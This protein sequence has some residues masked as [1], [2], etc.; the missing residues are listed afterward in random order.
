[1]VIWKRI[2][3]TVNTLNPELLSY[4]REF[5]FPL[6]SWCQLCHCSSDSR[7]QSCILGTVLFSKSILKS[8]LSIIFWFL[9]KYSKECLNIK[10][11]QYSILFV[12]KVPQWSVCVAS[13]RRWLSSVGGASRL[14]AK[15]S[16]SRISLSHYL[17]RQ[18]RS[19]QACHLRWYEWQ[20]PWRFVDF[21]FRQVIV[22]Y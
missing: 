4:N 16:G 5:S 19:H 15:P 10:C 1:M 8:I 18:F 22:F 20:S 12:V 17:P 3:H 14:W 7:W 9:F 11:I 6:H 2:N 21:T 13:T